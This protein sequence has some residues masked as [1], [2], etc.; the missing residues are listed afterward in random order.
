[1]KHKSTRGGARPGA[2]RKPRAKVAATE[3]ITI[4]L[5]PA[6]LAKLDRAREL[7]PGSVF[8]EPLATTAYRLV[9][10]ALSLLGKKS[11]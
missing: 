8:E 4:R 10:W 11:T 2:G 1:M 9:I 6:E 7:A 5:T 3:T